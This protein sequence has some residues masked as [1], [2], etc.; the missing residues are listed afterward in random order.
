MMKH[1]D[2]DDEISTFQNELF[3]QHQNPLEEEEED[4]VE[5]KKNFKKNFKKSYSERDQLAR[6]AH[7][8]LKSLLNERAYQRLKPYLK[9][10]LYINQSLFKWQEIS[11]NQQVDKSNLKTKDQLIHEFQQ[12]IPYVVQI[13]YRKDQLLQKICTSLIHDDL[14]P[15][16]HQEFKLYGL[17]QEATALQQQETQ[18]ALQQ[19]QTTALQ[20]QNQ[21]FVKQIYANQYVTRQDILNLKHKMNNLDYQQFKKNYKQLPKKND[22]K[23]NKEQIETYKQSIKQIYLLLFKYADTKFIKRFKQ[24]I[25]HKKLA[26]YYQKLIQ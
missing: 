9:D 4:L 13:L 3:H 25:K 1:N 14:L 6:K 18:E 17:Q 10:I 7:Q 22:L 2:I 26:H 8:Q 5:Q 12:I 23:L 16:Y 24:N 21:Q 20:Q 19:Q 11:Y 15:F